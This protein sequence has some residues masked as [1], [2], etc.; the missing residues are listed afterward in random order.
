MNIKSAFF[1]S[2]IILVMS[3]PN[4]NTQTPQQPYVAVQK[5]PG[6]EVRF[7][8]EAVMA[9]VYSSASSYKEVSSPGF[10]SLAG[11][12]FG[13]NAEEQKIAMT[14]P[15]YI[16]L[17]KEGSSMS[18]VMPPEYEPGDLP[19]PNNPSVHIETTK[20][21]YLAVIT[22]GGYANDQVIREQSEKLRAMLKANNIEYM[23]NFRFMGYN[24]PYK[25]WDR[26]NEVAVQIVWE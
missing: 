26:R 21:Q 13:D 16:D 4:G 18:F 24:A 7:Y 3:T 19:K 12:I 23:G 5:F 11:Y 22:F 2:A 20:P 8:P 1:L 17:D 10:R 14:A 15:V 9:R 6:F 25:F